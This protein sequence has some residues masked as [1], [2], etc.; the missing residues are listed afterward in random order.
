MRY[1]DLC[2][3][4]PAAFQRF[5][6]FTPELFHQMLDCLTPI[7][8]PFGRPSALSVADQLLVTVMYWRE[9]RTLYH[10][11]V[12]FGV[13][14]ATV[15]RIVHKVENRL[16]KSGKFSLP[17][18]KALRDGNLSVTLAVVDSSQSP[19]ER[20]KKNRNATTAAKRNAIP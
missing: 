14:E 4:N 9:Y 20:P 12:S 19:I 3:L 5:T 13:S 6:G 2:H 17:G 1:T 16:I 15:C 10:I 11:A 7:K 18:R 8:P